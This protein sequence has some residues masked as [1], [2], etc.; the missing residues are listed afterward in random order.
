MMNSLTSPVWGDQTTS[1]R[2]F[3]QHQLPRSMAA[4]RRCDGARCEGAKCGGAKV[5]A[6]RRSGGAGG[7]LLEWRAVCHVSQLLEILPDM[8]AMV[9]GEVADA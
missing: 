9:D 7:A 1:E 6:V 4:G 3:C 8:A 2:A 5:V